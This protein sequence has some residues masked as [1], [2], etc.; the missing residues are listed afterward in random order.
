MPCL[1]NES[2]AHMWEHYPKTTHRF[3]AFAQ[4]LDDQ[5]RVTVAAKWQEILV[6]PHQH[7]VLLHTMSPVLQ[8]SLPAGLTHWYGDL[9][10]LDFSCFTRPE[11]LHSAGTSPCMHMH[12]K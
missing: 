1:Q 2:E 6:S 5:K 12:I 9:I 4:R 3:I 10:N 8:A 11:P 7:A